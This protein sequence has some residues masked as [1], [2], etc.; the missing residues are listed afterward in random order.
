MNTRSASDTA[1]ATGQSVQYVAQGDLRV[2]QGITL[3]A[4]RRGTPWAGH[5]VQRCRQGGNSSL[6]ASA[7]VT[8]DGPVSAGG[9]PLRGCP[10]RRAA[11]SRDRHAGVPRDRHRCAR[12]RRPDPPRCRWRGRSHPS[13]GRTGRGRR[14]WAALPGNAIAGSP[15][16]QPSLPPALRSPAAT[17]SDASR[18]SIGTLDLRDTSTQLTFDNTQPY[19]AATGQGV[20]L[21]QLLFGGGNALTIAG[22]GGFG[23]Q[24]GI[25]VL[26]PNAAYQGPA[27]SANGGQLSF[28]LPADAVNGTT[29]LRASAPIATQGATVAMQAA[30]P[31]KRLLPGD[32]IMLIS[33]TTGTVANP[34]SH[35]LEYGAYRYLFDVQSA[36][37][38]TATLAST[39]LTLAAN[40]LSPLYR[41]RHRRAG[42]QRRHAVGRRPARPRARPVLQSGPGPH[43]LH[44]QEPQ[45]GPRQ[46]RVRLRPGGATAAGDY[47]VAPLVEAGRTR[48]R[49]QASSAACR[50]RARAA[51]TTSAWASWRATGSWAARM[52]RP[53]CAA[54]ACAAAIPTTSTAAPTTAVVRTIGAHA[55]LG[56]VMPLSERGQLDAYA[57]LQWQ[58]LAAI[59][60]ATTRATSSAMTP[61]RRCARAWARATSTRPATRRALR[62]RGLGA[63]RQDRG[64]RGSMARPC[65]GHQW[66]R[67]GAGSGRALEPS[68]SWS[69]RLSAQGQFGA[70]Q[71]IGRGFR[72]SALLRRD[73]GSAQVG[74]WA[75]TVSRICITYSP[76]SCATK[77][78]VQAASAWTNRATARSRRSRPR[79]S[80]PETRPQADP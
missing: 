56:H 48:Y 43:P 40:K 27:L 7:N 57:R 74:R 18:V 50:P 33:A 42:R 53:R 75:S 36:S 9:H 65:S 1:Q 29:M 55:M 41:R 24:G 21:G 68:P 76:Q 62:G 20:Q 54:D 61:R 58:R 77:G 14:A 8:S 26:G 44:R 52:P 3:Q 15:Y 46:R 22:N 37:A 45:A 63:G 2:A 13:P 64:A 78:G 35:I 11:V 79:G 51:S 66:R 31:L 12:L 6:Q 23:F 17:F 70:R 71:G 67:D 5:Q 32:R 4:D 80:P 38:L 25:T 59:P 49:G 19:N 28:L 69:L 60:C 10:T 73:A 47:V 72:L 16:G 34:G 39:N 30:G